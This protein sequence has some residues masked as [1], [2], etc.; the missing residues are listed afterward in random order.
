MTPILDKDSIKILTQGMNQD[1]VKY[2]AE[3]NS[4]CQDI[5]QKYPE[6]ID[7]GQEDDIIYIAKIMAF[8]DKFK[9]LHWAAANHSYHEA[10]GKFGDELEDYKDNIAEN[11]QSI[12]GQFKADEFTKLE[13]PLGDDPLVIIN[14]LKQCVANWFNL[15]IDDM[16]YEGCRNATSGFLEVIHKYVYL[17]RLCKIKQG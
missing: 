14:E 15:H 4:I 2:C 1:Q 17:F 16:E 9:N 12:I 8:T 11:I 7:N 3:I 5:D 6:A 10:L 13:L